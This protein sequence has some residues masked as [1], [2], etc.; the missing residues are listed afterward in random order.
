[1]MLALLLQL[2]PAPIEQAPHPL[3][4]RVEVPADWY[5][6][7]SLRAEVYD[8]TMK[9]YRGDEYRV[10]FERT[11]GE[12]FLTGDERIPLGRRPSTVLVKVNTSPYPL[13][14][15][16]NIYASGV[17]TNLVYDNPG[18]VSMTFL[19]SKTYAHLQ[20]RPGTTDDEGNPTV[21]NELHGKCSIGPIA[22]RNETPR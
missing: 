16:T 10:V 8:C 20:F 13:S 21:F 6:R 19:A 9:T 18:Y 5:E 22:P 14:T 2:S 1:M 17:Q 12:A 11:G 3:D 15:P 7:Y 4:T